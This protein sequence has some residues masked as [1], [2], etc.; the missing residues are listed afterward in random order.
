MVEFDEKNPNVSKQCNT[1]LIASI[2]NSL[3]RNI[4]EQ[5]GLNEKDNSSFISNVEIKN[6]IQQMPFDNSLNVTTDQ[7]EDQEAEEYRFQQGRIPQKRNKR[8]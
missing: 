1:A 3:D 5:M 6:A 8:N 7:E 4:N 2:N